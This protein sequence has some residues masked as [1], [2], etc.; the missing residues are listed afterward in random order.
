MSNKARLLLFMFIIGSITPFVEVFAIIEAF[1]LIIPFAILI[2]IS[3]LYLLMSFFTKEV[4]IK[5]A[6]YFFCLIPLFISS[7]IGSTFI[8]DKVQRVRS[9]SLL[10]EIENIRNKTGIFPDHYPTY[11]GITYIK[12]KDQYNYRIEYS[13]G[14]LVREVYE[15]DDKTWISY[16]WRD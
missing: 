11:V 5:T 14:F 16:G 7:Q 6:L 13:R 9:E 12:E 3:F 2:F 4:S 8:V 15:H 10:T 1:F